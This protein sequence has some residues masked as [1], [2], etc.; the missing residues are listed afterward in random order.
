MKTSNEF[1]IGNHGITYV[2]DNFKNWFYSTSFTPTKKTTLY[3]QKLARSMNDTE[4]L[5]EYNPTEL[6]LGDVL[7]ALKEGLIEKSWWGG[8]LY[9]KDS[10]G[11]LRT[12][13]VYWLDVGWVVDADS[14]EDPGRWLDGSQVF[15]RLVLE[16]SEP[17]PMTLSPSDTLT[18]SAEEQA[19]LKNV[20]KRLL[21]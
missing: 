10:I 12:V 19:V 8:I 2:G 21:K 13:L 11:V 4:I 9:V 14:V 5:K 7:Y 15:S 20:L 18:L 6:T 1:K 17:S 3:S 16:S